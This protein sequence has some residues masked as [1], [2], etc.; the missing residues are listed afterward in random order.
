M[1]R[2]VFKDNSSRYQVDGRTRT[3]KEV[4][5]LL[6]TRGVDLDNHRFLILQGEVEQISLMP[7][8]GAKE[9]EDG[10][11]EYLEDI[12]GSNRF[13]APIAT[14]AGLE[15]EVRTSNN[16]VYSLTRSLLSRHTPHFI[17]LLQN[18]Y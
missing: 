13:V 9:G 3:F 6:R 11:L 7:P 1:S 17:T 12:V 16:R 8:K 4:A 5:A 15:D 14:A 2:T 10:M 18:V